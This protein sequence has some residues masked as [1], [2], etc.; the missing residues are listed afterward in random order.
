[1]A[2]PPRRR[3]APTFC[4]WRDSKPLH[5]C[6]SM[7]GRLY[8]A[9]R[10]DLTGK[11]QPVSGVDCVA[12]MKRYLVSVGGTAR[13]P[14]R[15]GVALRGRGGAGEGG[16]GRDRRGVGEGGPRGPGGSPHRGGVT[17]LGGPFRCGKDPG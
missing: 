16:G 1:S 13:C 15:A 5:S 14:S 9:S 4:G 7:S 8:G 12:A 10:S 17:H 2:A 6:E 3:A 11:E